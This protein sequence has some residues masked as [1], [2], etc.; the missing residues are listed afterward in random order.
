M[1]LGFS[2]AI[3]LKI[4]NFPLARPFH[5]QGGFAFTT[6]IPPGVAAEVA[7]GAEI[8]VAENGRK[9]G[10]GAI[11]HRWIRERGSGVFSLWG[12][13]LYFSSHD[14]TDP[15]WNERAYEIVAIDW[16]PFYEAAYAGAGTIPV[17]RRFLHDY[18]AHYEASP[19]ASLVERC[20]TFSMLHQEALALL[21]YLAAAAKGPVLE[22]GAFLGAG[23]IMMASAAA[24]VVTVELGGKSWHPDYKDT[25]IDE[26][27][28]KNLRDFKVADRV[29]VVRGWTYDPRVREEVVE[30]LGGEKAGLFVVDADGCIGETFELYGGHLADDALVVLDDYFV[31]EGSRKDLPVR[32]WVAHAIETGRVRDLGVYPFGTWIGQL[33]RQTG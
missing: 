33:Q 6:K 12:E 13:D 23:T 4:K 3:R 5:S 24:R 8:Y 9:L 18:A 15:N 19:H 1:P 17:T 7:T 25:D 20:R 27:L 32:E 2:M 11:E 14:R 22:L 29:R 28:A 26:T 16:R 21:F 31:F 10:P 30:A